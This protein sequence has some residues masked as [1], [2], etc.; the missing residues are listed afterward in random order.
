[1]A[2]MHSR[3][4]FSVAIDGND[5][6][7]VVHLSIQS[8]L[9]V[10]VVYQCN[11]HIPWILRVHAAYIACLRQ[12]RGGTLAIFMEL[13]VCARKGWN[14]GYIFMVM[15]LYK[16]RWNSGYIHVWL[17]GHGQIFMN[18]TALGTVATMN[19]MNFT[20]LGT[21]SLVLPRPLFLSLMTSLA[22]PISVTARWMPMQ[23]PHAHSVGRWH[24]ETWTVWKN[25]FIFFLHFHFSKW[26]ISLICEGCCW[27]D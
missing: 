26:T 23:G 27:Q 2:T 24:V 14:S 18:F 17:A 7:N 4:F 20:A 22:L 5:D 1:M 25:L 19:F 6:V 3:C 15:C 21:V 16:R 11:I 13:C 8:P 12:R 9:V 10:L